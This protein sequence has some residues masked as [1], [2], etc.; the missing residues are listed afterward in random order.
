MLDLGLVAATRPAEVGGQQLPQTVGT[1][2]MLYIM[3]GN[4]GAAGFAGL[5]TGAAHLIEAFG[6]ETLKL[7]YM[8][9]MYGGAWT[10]TMALTEPHAG[11]SLADVR[12]R[13]RPA[14]AGIRSRAEALV[15]EASPAR[16]GR[17]ALHFTVVQRAC[18]TTSSVMP[19]VSFTMKLG[20]CFTSS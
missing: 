17:V 1:A 12:T 8:E 6:D 7:V 14:P 5:T 18:E 3:A 4:C 16:V 19:S 2:A 11:S 10:G 13:A 15:E 20:R 9:K